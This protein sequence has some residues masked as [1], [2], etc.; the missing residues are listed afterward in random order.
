MIVLVLLLFDQY[1]PFA[2]LKPKNGEVD[3]RIEGRVA[4]LS[5]LMMGIPKKYIYSPTA[6][7]M[8]R[9]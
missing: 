7:R 1:R 3:G 6:S 9:R 5:R 4:G 8:Q 2:I